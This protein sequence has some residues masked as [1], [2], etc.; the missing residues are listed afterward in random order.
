LLFDPH[1]EETA[2]DG[3]SLVQALVEGYGGQVWVEDDEPRGS[4][5][6]V[7]LPRADTEQQ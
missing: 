7:E 2:S 1:N 3:L 4:I 5:F 6:T